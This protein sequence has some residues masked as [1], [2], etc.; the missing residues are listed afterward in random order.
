L[1]PDLF[2]RKARW[3]VVA[4]HRSPVVYTSVQTVPNNNNFTSFEMHNPRTMSD[5]IAAAAGTNVGRTNAP[6]RLN[7]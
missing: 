2:A 7:F 1:W 5:V 6:M 4:V 3:R